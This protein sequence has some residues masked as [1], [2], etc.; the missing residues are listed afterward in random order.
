MK[1]LT[2]LLLL[3]VSVSAWSQPTISFK[4][5]ANTNC[6]SIYTIDSIMLSHG[7]TRDSVYSGNP[8]LYLLS[9]SYSHKV[10]TGRVRTDFSYAYIDNTTLYPTLK[11]SVWKNMSNHQIMDDEVGHINGEVIRKDASSTL[12]A[13]SHPFKGVTMRVVVDSCISI[14]QIYSNF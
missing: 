5:P 3:L 10:D 6:K 1:H 2:L 11:I 9:V 14:T 4:E 12:K 7:F 13:Y 8:Y